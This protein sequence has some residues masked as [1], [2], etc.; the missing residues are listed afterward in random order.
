MDFTA[1]TQNREN[2]DSGVI[3]P[4]SPSVVAAYLFTV[5]SHNESVI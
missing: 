5:F 2:P 4:T 1:S 3:H